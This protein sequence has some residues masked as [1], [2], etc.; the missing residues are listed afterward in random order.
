[1]D[2]QIAKV[3]KECQ[4]SYYHS[5]KYIIKYNDGVIFF[6]GVNVF[7]SVGIAKRAILNHSFGKNTKA[8]KD[9]DNIKLLDDMIANDIIK[10][11]KL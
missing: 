8:S 4:G 1:M 9:P 6:G 5:N 2:N 10:I 3:L 11:E 7:K